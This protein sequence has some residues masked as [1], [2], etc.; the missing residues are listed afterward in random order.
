MLSIRDVF[1]ICRERES[2]GYRVINAHIGAPSHEPPLPVSEVLSEL[3]EVGRNYLP[4]TGTDS[5]KEAVSEYA[6][7]FLGRDYDPSRVVITNGGVQALLIAFK[8]AS[9]KGK[10]LVPKPGFVHYFEQPEEFGFEIGYYN[11]LSEDLVGEIEG[12][13]EGV[14]AVLVNYPN[15]P[16]GYSQDN[17][18][19]R[20]L[21]DLL[22]AKGVLLIN[23]AAYSQIY[24]GEK[25]EIVGDVVVDTF[26][27]TLSLPG[28]RI[29]YIYWG[30][31]DYKR[32]GRLSYLTTA[33]ASEPTQL[34][35]QRMLSALTEDYFS[36]VRQKY[37]SVRD[38]L[39]KALKGLGF[40]FPEPKGAFY[41]YPQHDSIKDSEVFIRSLL[42]REDYVIG[43]VPGSAFRGDKRRMRI[44]YGKL[45]VEDVQVIKEVFKELVSE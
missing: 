20:K 27:K 5:T 2:Q 42:S 37:R 8:L 28:M 36:R 32:A 18:T 16:T 30:T 6:S 31:E 26:S 11:P 25:P 40:K 23:D 14:G 7:R 4:F 44:S 12:K 34:L 22:S 15:N 3:G 43:V 41:L 21:W 33:G 10:I 17:S 24:Y 9:R 1:S 45:T 38:E 19:L 39:V 35:L 13:L 29:G